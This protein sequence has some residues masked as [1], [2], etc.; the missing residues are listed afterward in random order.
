MCFV[1]KLSHR[2]KYY[3]GIYYFTTFVQLCLHDAIDEWYHLL[4]QF[5]M[6]GDFNDK[7]IVI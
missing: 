3:Y 5:I 2:N 7:K 1:P 6:F 4:I